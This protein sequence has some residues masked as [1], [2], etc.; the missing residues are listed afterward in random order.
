MRM[1]ASYSLMT[2]LSSLGDNLPYT[3]KTALGRHYTPTASLRPRSYALIDDRA[4][5]TIWSC[6]YQRLVP[7]QV[8]EPWRGAYG[9]GAH[10]DHGSSLDQKQYLDMSYGYL[11]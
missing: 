8:S 1:P 11:S 6:F 3:L 7:W 9:P 5:T 10:P 2:G 4:R